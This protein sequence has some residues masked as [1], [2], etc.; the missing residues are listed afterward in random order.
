MCVSGGCAYGGDRGGLHWSSAH[1]SKRHSQQNRHQRTQHYSTVCSGQSL[2]AHIIC[3]S[4]M[5]VLLSKSQSIYLLLCYLAIDLVFVCSVPLSIVYQYHCSI[6][7][8]IYCYS[9]IIDLAFICLLV[10]SIELIR[11][12]LS[13]VHSICLFVHLVYR[14]SCHL[15]YIVLS[16]YLLHALVNFVI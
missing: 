1:S 9:I 8:C 16:F 10:L 12:L 4:M 15:L 3:L 13:T 6:I 7:N 11:S 14:S 5:F 2:R